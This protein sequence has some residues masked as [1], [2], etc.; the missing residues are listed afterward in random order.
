MNTFGAAWYR[1]SGLV[2]DNALVRSN[3]YGMIRQRALLT[4]PNC[5]IGTQSGYRMSRRR[6]RS[7]SSAWVF[8]IDDDILLGLRA[9]QESRYEKAACCNPS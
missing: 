6:H 1:R 5:E 4:G 8:R 2:T 7:R 3:V 9:F